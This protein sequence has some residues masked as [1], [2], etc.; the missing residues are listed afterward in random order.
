M[1]RL[2]PDST[3]G[4]VA[5]LVAAGV[6]VFA[7]AFAVG[8]WQGHDERPLP[9]AAPLV[10]LAHAVAVTGLPTARP[11]PDLRPRPAPKPKPSAKPSPKPRPA[12]AAP[13]RR[14]PKPPPPVVIDGSG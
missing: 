10:P 3:V 14:K 1:R 4:V 11:L 7:V 12:P 5:M 9:R 13:A 2:V 6:V 8:R